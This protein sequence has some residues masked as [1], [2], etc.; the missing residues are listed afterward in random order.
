MLSSRAIL[1]KFKGKIIEDRQLRYIVSAYIE[2]PNIKF[3]EM[4]KEEFKDPGGIRSSGID[5]CTI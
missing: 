1:N 3:E 4:N 2:D 5:S